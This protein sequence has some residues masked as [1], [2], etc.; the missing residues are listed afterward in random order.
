M[1]KRRLW[2]GLNTIPENNIALEKRSLSQ[3]EKE[4]QVSSKEQWEK[5]AEV[6]NV[7]IPGE[8]SLPEETEI[9][10]FRVMPS[11]ESLQSATIASKVK[12]RESVAE[13]WW[14]DITSP[15]QHKVYVHPSQPGYLVFTFD[16]KIYGE[17]AA[18]FRSQMFK[19]DFDSLGISREKVDVQTDYNLLIIEQ[20]ALEAV[21]KARGEKLSLEIA[22]APTL[23][24][25]QLRDKKIQL[26]S[27]SDENY[28]AKLRKKPAYF[29]PV[30]KGYIFFACD[31]KIEGTK[32]STHY[33]SALKLAL[34]S[35]G[36]DKKKASAQEKHNL[37]IVDQ[38]SLEVIFK[39]RNYEPLSEIYEAG[40][41]LV[42]KLLLASSRHIYSAILTT[43]P[44]T[45]T[46]TARTTS[47]YGNRS[48][49]EQPITKGSVVE[50]P[51]AKRVTITD[52]EGLPIPS[53]KEMLDQINQAPPSSIG[54]QSNRATFPQ[55]LS[56]IV[57][58][59][60]NVRKFRSFLEA[61][62]KECRLSVELHQYVM[63]LSDNLALLFKQ[64]LS[65]FDLSKIAPDIETY[66]NAVTSFSDRLKPLYPMTYRTT[67]MPLVSELNIA[68]EPETSHRRL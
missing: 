50:T 6:V 43:P 40:P 66:R 1:K 23:L 4:S 30:K 33:A 44:T 26:L 49:R 21:F 57:V 34:S 46:T 55:T 7:E 65:S 63:A 12:Q 54:N 10:S 51:S 41:A 32:A 67:L 60:S 20:S 28:I 18:I 56:P 27:R 16:T 31:S 37:L 68:M 48:E 8:K 35:L 5:E 47:D 29:H 13:I 15:S 11:N 36:M 22:T 24:K 61:F 9:D 59:H 17:N 45:V 38:A 19:R 64:L 2:I 53:F 42:E 14:N 3:F 25:D 39:H 62:P 58:L 52:K